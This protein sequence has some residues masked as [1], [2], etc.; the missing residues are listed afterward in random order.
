MTYDEFQATM[1]ANR[2][3][4]TRHDDDLR[5]IYLGGTEELKEFALTKKLMG[6]KNIA[7]I[8]TRSIAYQNRFTTWMA[9]KEWKATKQEVEMWAV[10]AEGY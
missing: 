7:W 6:V 5:D 4:L 3:K 9:D 1:R 2:G 10:S 8:A